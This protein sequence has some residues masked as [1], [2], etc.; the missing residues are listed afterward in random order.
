[1]KGFDIDYVEPE[2]HE[3]ALYTA[4]KLNLGRAAEYLLKRGADTEI[5][6]KTFGWTPIFVAATEGF[7]N[8][9]KLAFGR[10]WS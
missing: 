8:I 4:A 5:S 10:K 2:T 7:Y 9:A 6:E 3:T 1:M